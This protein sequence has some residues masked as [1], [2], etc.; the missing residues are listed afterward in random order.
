[1]HDLR[2]SIR[3]LVSALDII[4][5]VPVEADVKVVRRTLKKHLEMFGPLRDT[6]TQMIAVSSL[7]D[8]FPELQEFTNRLASEEQRLVKKLEK[9]MKAIDIEPL[10]AS[11]RS[12]LK[13]LRKIQRDPV[14]GAEITTAMIGT[15]EAAFER[16]VECRKRVKVKDPETIHRLRVAFK[17]F[18]YMVEVL[19]PV[20]GGVTD[21]ML[22]QMHDF[23][24]AMGRIQDLGVLSSSYEEFLR[25]RDQA[26]PKGHRRVLKE[27]ERR[28]REHITEFLDIIGAI[29]MFWTPRTAIEAGSAERHTVQAR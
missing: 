23:Q 1:M 7:L 10:V 29:E 12:S 3:R 26:V 14:R 2:V 16:A 6:Q 24:D 20:L 5:E 13:S 22:R 8:R 18:R 28:R 9:K 21:E 19:Q 15:A 4:K 25:S 27:L 11:I 17:K